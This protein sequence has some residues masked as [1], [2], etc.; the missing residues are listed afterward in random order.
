MN[1]FFMSKLPYATRVSDSAAL[2]Q[3]T[4]LE[5]ITGVTTALTLEKNSIALFNDRN[6][7]LTTGLGNYLKD[8]KYVR[9]V[10]GRGWDGDEGVGYKHII[11][12]PIYRQEGN[13]IQNV[14]YCPPVK[15]ISFIGAEKTSSPVGDLN[16]PSPL[17]PTGNDTTGYIAG[18]VI[19]KT[20]NNLYHSNGVSRKQYIVD[21]P[22]NIASGTATEQKSYVCTQL[23]SKINKDKLVT[24]VAIGSTSSEIGVQLTGK[25]GETFLVT[26]FDLLEYATMVTPSTTGIGTEPKSMYLGCGRPK[27]VLD[28]EIRAETEQGR[29]TGTIDERWRSWKDDSQVCVTDACGYA[30][31]TIIKRDLPTGIGEIVKASIIK[32]KVNIVYEGTLAGSVPTGSW[33]IANSNNTIVTL[34]T[35]FENIFGV[36]ALT[37]A[38]AVEDATA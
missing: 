20:N 15:Q 25:Y 16:L 26:A 36:G 4:K 23:V 7:L 3:G 10:E 38:T 35:L 2:P 31:T 37:T 28:M 13:T 8:V 27:Q 12:E 34:E 1:K 17:I 30:M 21:I 5:A 33:T 19:E 32:P 18:C 24:A 22:L 6:E 11:G 29:M 9:I 14:T